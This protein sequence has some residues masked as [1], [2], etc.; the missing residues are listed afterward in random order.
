MAR[1][2]S[3]NQR[4]RILGATVS[5]SERVDRIQ[6]GKKMG[7]LCREY[8]VAQPAKTMLGMQ[9]EEKAIELRPDVLGIA[10]RISVL[11]DTD[12]ARLASPSVDVSKQMMM[13]REIVSDRK[14]AG[15]QWLFTPQGEADR[16]ETIEIRLVA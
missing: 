7:E 1:V 6:V 2:R 3:N 9:P 13:D 16:L 4:E 8:L 15:R 11:G 10:K 5:L 12:R 14:L